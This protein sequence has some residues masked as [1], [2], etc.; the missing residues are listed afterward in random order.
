MTC[1]EASEFLHDYV[2]AALDEVVCG[3]FDAHLTDCPNCHLF[4]S[5]YRATITESRRACSDTEADASTVFPEELVR[6]ILAA[7]AKERG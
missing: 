2:S 4:V 5:Q 6:A 3:E 1:R 7:L